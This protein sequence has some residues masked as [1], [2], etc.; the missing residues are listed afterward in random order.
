MPGLSPC[1][2]DCSPTSDKL[3]F[4]TQPQATWQLAG[5]RFRRMP[6]SKPWAAYL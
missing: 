5:T 4:A 3:N 2:E 6:A 1:T